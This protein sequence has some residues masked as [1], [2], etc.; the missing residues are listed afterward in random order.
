MEKTTH[1]CGKEKEDKQCNVK[2]GRG[3]AEETKK[4]H[5]VLYVLY[6]VDGG[7]VRLAY[8]NPTPSPSPPP[9]FFFT[10]KR[11]GK[12]KKGVLRFEKVGFTA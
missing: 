1:L 7:R 5:S 8:S 11:I 3:F 6:A 4:V 2:G 9:L 10:G 12:K